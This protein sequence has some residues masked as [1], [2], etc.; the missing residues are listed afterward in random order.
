MHSSGVSEDSD[1]ILIYKKKKKKR[2]L[3]N[4]LMPFRVLGEVGPFV[5]ASCLLAPLHSQYYL[6]WNEY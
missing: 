6:T 2:L 4:G 1:S 3:K 5:N